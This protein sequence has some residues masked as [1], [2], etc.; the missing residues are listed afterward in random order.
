LRRRGGH[1]RCE[2]L[3]REGGGEDVGTRE[4]TRRQ[5]AADGEGARQ[6]EAGEA[7][8]GRGR[9]GERG[10]ET[11]A[12]VRCTHRR[13]LHRRLALHRR[14]LQLRRSCAAA[15]AGVRR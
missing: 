15:G 8:W 14:D 10:D 4:L 11:R 6:G 1:E 5:R 7:E 9:R 2:N 12:E 3:E 13:G